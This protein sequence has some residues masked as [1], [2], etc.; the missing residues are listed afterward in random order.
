MLPPLRMVRRGRITNIADHGITRLRCLLHGLCRP[1][2]E[3]RVY[4]MR[5]PCVYGC[6]GELLGT[7]HVVAHKP[8]L[9]S[10]PPHGEK[11]LS[12]AYKGDRPPAPPHCDPRRPPH[13]SV[14][15]HWRDRT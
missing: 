2:T 4:N 6:H 14:L 13:R 15:V 7:L 9:T 5:P 11:Y 12:P 10:L 1:A 3:P 8:R